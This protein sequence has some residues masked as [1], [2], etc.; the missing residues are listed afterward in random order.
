MR[1]S[2]PY[3]GRAEA[4]E[5]FEVIE[6]FEGIECFEGIEFFDFFEVTV[7][8]TARAFL[9]PGSAGPSA[10]GAES[11][12]LA[13]NCG[14]CRGPVRRGDPTAIRSRQLCVR[15]SWFDLG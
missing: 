14:R 4:V 9:P 7:D 11:C 6:F 13:R 15:Q 1:S 2:R 3:P 8:A 12:P 10:G 5:F